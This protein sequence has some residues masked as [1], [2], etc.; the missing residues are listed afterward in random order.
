MLERQLNLSEGWSA[1]ICQTGRLRAQGAEVIAGADAEQELGVLPVFDP[2]HT[3]SQ[4]IPFT[5]DSPIGSRH[6]VPKTAL[7]GR[8]MGGSDYTDMDAEARD[9]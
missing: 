2:H 6:V 7:W 1:P 5:K 9:G 8:Q 3:A 4:A